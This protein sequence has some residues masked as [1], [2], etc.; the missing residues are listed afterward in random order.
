MAKT[1]ELNPAFPEGAK[2]VLE[3]RGKRI[4]EKE[5]NFN[6]KRYAYIYITSDPSDGEKLPKNA[7]GEDVPNDKEG[8]SIS[9]FDTYPKNGYTIGIPPTGGHLS[10]YDIENGKR[11]LKPQITSVTMNQSGGG[12][13]YNSFIREID[14]AFKAY[15]LTQMNAIEH[16]LFRLGS[17]IKINYGWL[18][19]LDSKFETGA[20]IMTVYNFGFTM[21]SDGTFNCT[22]K[23]IAGDVFVD[24]SRTGGLIKLTNDGEIKAMGE[25]PTNPVDVSGAL[26]AM[27]KNAFGLDAD[28]KPADDGIKN[29]QLEYEKAEGDS[30]VDLF[31]GGI[32]NVGDS[33]GY[34]LGIGADDPYRAPFTTLKSLIYLLNKTSG[35]SEKQTYKID[36]TG[37]GHYGSIQPVDKKFGSSDPRKYILP[38]V[39]ANY[40]EGNDF[41]SDLEGEGFG[42]TKIENILISIN[43]ITQIFSNKGK[44][45]N[46]TFQ[47]PTAKEVIDDLSGRIANVTGGLVQLRVERVEKE[48]Q[49]EYLIVNKVNKLQ[50]QKPKPPHRFITVGEKSHVTN[51]SIESEFDADLMLIMTRGNVR[52][53][54]IALGPL[55]S[56]YK[57]IPDIGLS[58]EAKDAK[59]DAENEA[60]NA[61][62]S[63]GKDG[64]DDMKASTIANTMKLLLTT[65]EGKDPKKTIQPVLP[66]Q[67]KL[68]ITLPGI[69]NIPFLAPVE[70]DRLPARFKSAGVKFLITST[71]HSFDGQGKWETNFKAV[72]TMGDI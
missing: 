64:L 8:D 46:E 24:S 4:K 20:V 12:D 35:D 45:V 23:G 48:R 10:L 18:Q 21:E 13:I 43:E 60:T 62:F 33:D 36:T 25:K 7:K 42:D 52:N 69:D 55:K 28:E 58:D 66:F 40:G 3:S 71:E 39:F 65:P 56:V 19:P 59:K 63:V 41:Q 44:T 54:N 31:M 68:N 17:N 5:L 30:N 16:D 6:Y 57:E 32:K 53:G 67:L 14:I 11:R 34:V 37:E 1:F 9:L 29:G 61:K 47:P 15:S 51:I 72:M 50:E 27:Y 38:G 22:M 26:I 49:T 70:V 2:K